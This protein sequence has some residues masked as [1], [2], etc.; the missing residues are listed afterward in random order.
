MI[1]VALVGLTL[2]IVRGTIFRPLQ[3]VWPALF[4]CSQCAGLW[5]GSVAGA[6]GVVSMQ[7]GF[8]VLGRS[9]DA[10]LVG[11]ATSLLSLAADAVLLKLLGDPNEKTP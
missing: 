5:V 1:Y 10:V 3:R 6:T 4:Q 2:I 8:G 9:V 7:F 11:G